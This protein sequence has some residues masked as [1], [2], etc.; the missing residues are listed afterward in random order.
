MNLQYTPAIAPALANNPFDNCPHIRDRSRLME[1]PGGLPRYRFRPHEPLHARDRKAFEATQS[2]LRDAHY[3][4]VMARSVVN[5]HACRLS[6][7]EE[8]GHPANATMLCHDLYAFCDE[9]PTPVSGAVSFI[10]C[11]KGASVER[12]SAFEAA[13]WQQLE[14][15]HEVD[16]QHFEWSREVDSDPAS[17]N[18]SFSVGARAF[19][20]IGMHPGASRLAR[21][22][23]MPAIVFN[24]HEQFVEL[25]KT[26]KFD[27]VRDTVQGRD[28]RLQGSINPMATDFGERSEAVQYSGRAVG[29]NWVCPFNA[30]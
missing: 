18:F 8:L 2:L 20:V 22:M 3:P 30:G 16:K 28:M 10:A 15:V 9:F 1:T 14:D 5:R 27:G 29:R 17:P 19:F 23:P 13:L 25:R 6:T 26:G 7:Y 11:F 4:C 24:L 12:E 21:R